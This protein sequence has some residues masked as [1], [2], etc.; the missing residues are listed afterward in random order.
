MSRNVTTNYYSI[1]YGEI[2]LKLQL[3]EIYVTLSWGLP[4]AG[5]GLGRKSFGPSSKRRRAKKLYT[6]SERLD[7]SCKVTWVCS[8]RVNLYSRHI[9][10][11]PRKTFLAGKVG[12]CMR[13]TTSTPSCAECHEIWDLK[14]PGTLCATPGLLRDSFTLLLPRSTKICNTLG[15]RPPSG[16]PGRLPPPPLSSALSAVKLL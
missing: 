9:M 8:E 15:H 5:L 7:L 4:R 10:T 2:R 14:T 6:N 3:C 11:V 13:L 16:P 12:R 1:L